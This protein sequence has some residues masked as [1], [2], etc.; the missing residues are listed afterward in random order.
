MTGM[1][2]FFTFSGVVVGPT[3]FATIYGIIGSYPMTY[4]IMAL[5]PIIGTLSLRGLGSAPPR[6]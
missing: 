2:L 1:V 4:G 6:H 5:F 3:F